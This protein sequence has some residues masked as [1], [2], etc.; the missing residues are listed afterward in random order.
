MTLIQ[1]KFNFAS[2]DR[3]APASTNS[4]SIVDWASSCI[5]GQQAAKVIRKAEKKRLDT[6]PFQLSNPRP[7]LVPL[8]PWSKS[9]KVKAPVS[10]DL[11]TSMSSSEVYSQSRVTKSEIGYIQVSLSTHGSPLCPLCLSQSQ[12]TTRCQCPALRTSILPAVMRHRSECSSESRNIA[13][14]ACV[15]Y[16]RSYIPISRLVSRTQVPLHPTTL[17]FSSLPQ[18]VSCQLCICY[19]LIDRYTS[20]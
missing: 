1:T 17:K 2:I 19:L 15:A 8:R 13:Y 11:R 12:G 9:I 6:F 18:P 5:G 14:S 3:D 10:H 4:E 20:T 7:P 16:K